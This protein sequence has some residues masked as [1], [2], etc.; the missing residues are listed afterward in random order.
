MKSRIK[1]YQIILDEKLEALQLSAKEAENHDAVVY[2]Q[3]LKGML[4]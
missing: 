3:A 2:L 4:D 1:I